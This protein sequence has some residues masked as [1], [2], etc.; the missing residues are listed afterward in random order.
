MSLE[1]EVFRQCCVVISAWGDRGRRWG[2]D[3]PFTDF[4][5]SHP[6]LCLASLLIAAKCVFLLFFFSKLGHTEG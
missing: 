4:S 6:P 5:A 2:V 1:D 3:T